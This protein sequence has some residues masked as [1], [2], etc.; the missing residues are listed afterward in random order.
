MTFGNIGL[1]LTRTGISQQAGLD[2]SLNTFKER[3]IHA[4]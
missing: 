4:G 2:M 3:V 1:V